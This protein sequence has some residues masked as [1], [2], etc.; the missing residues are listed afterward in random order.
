MRTNTIIILLSA[1]MNL[2]LA[3]AQTISIKGK[4]YNP[5]RQPIEYANLQLL[6]QDSLFIKGTTSD[7]NGSFKLTATNNSTYRLIISSTGY[8]TSTLTLENIQTDIELGEIILREA[9]VTLDEVSVTANRTVH[10]IDRQITYPSPIVRESSSNALDVLYKSALPR[11]IVNP[12]E[13]TISLIGSETVKLRI[14]GIDANVNEVAAIPAKE[15]IRI[16]YYDNP[17][18]LFEGQALIDILVKR[19]ET[20]GYFYADISNSPHVGFGNN[21]FS[22]KLNYKNSEWSANYSLSYRAY[23][24][25]ELEATT[26]YNFPDNPV[27]KQTEGIPSRFGYQT[28]D[29]SL[30]YN[31][32]LPDK[33]VFNA[34]F[35]GSF[36]NYYGHDK[37]YNRYSDLPGIRFRQVKEAADKE[38]NPQFDLYY[39][40]VISS[41][42]NLMF[43]LVGGYINSTSDREQIEMNEAEEQISNYLNNTDG[44]KYSVIAEG[45]HQVKWDNVQLY[46]GINYKMGYAENNYAGDISEKTTLKNTDL[47]LY[48]QLQGK[49]KRLNYL[50]GVGVSYSNFSDRN[51]GFDFWSFRPSVSLSYNLGEK[52][53][54]QYKFNLKPVIPSLSSLSDVEQRLDQFEIRK[55][56]PELKPFRVYMNQLIVNYQNKV[57]QCYAGIGHAYYKNVIMSKIEY[58]EAQNAFI[59]YQINQKFYQNTS[60][61]GNI[62]WQIIPN[63]LSI[64]VNGQISW[65]QSKGYQYDH[66]YTGY[67]GSGQINYRIKQWNFN[68]GISSRY[69]NLW[70]ESINYGEWWS[71]LGV[72][73]KFK[74][75][76]VGITGLNILTN[77]YSGGNKNLSQQMPGT[78]WTYIYDSAPIF[79]LNLSWNINWGKKSNAEQKAL[80][81]KDSD[82]GIFKVQ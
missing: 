28:H 22:T 59:S 53:F 19:R 8:V 70:A 15:I 81:N 47:Y 10:K 33:R 16:D 32:T 58:N 41:S 12:S 56:N 7:L 67:F 66:K 64:N 6:N 79:C 43:N 26:T 74:E 39:K 71:E 52:I 57:L 27:V 76:S 4:V 69:N 49:L 60:L 75:L 23:K 37:F 24:K 40:E 38:I 80:Q 30:S 13:K 5:Q 20:G 62:N 48:T 45:I 18:V 78:S 42:Q 31:Y 25:R 54:L 68:F 63:K 82:S 46:S 65:M 61:N 73:Y 55:G 72:N 36:L 29:I 14:N 77:R 11:V 35:I 3:N 50:L 1:I 51:N 2:T 44:K 34:S 9:T 17:G 21:Q